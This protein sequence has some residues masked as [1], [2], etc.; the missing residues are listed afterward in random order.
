MSEERMSLTDT[1]Y[2]AFSKTICQSFLYSDNY[3]MAKCVH[4][5]VSM[6]QKREVNTLQLLQTMIDDGKI[7]IVPKMLGN[8]KLMHVQLKNMLDLQENSWGVLEPIES[9]PIKVNYPDCIIVPMLAGDIHRNRLGYGKGY[10]DRFLMKS[11]AFKIG[12]CF[13]FAI[14]DKL[15]IEEHDEK[16]SLIISEKRIL[17]AK[18]S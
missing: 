7:V 3:K 17:S 2:I 15:P 4:C 18:H 10:Y 9:N 1:E 16:L 14:V 8:G 12:F 5:Y 6:N 13:D 11:S